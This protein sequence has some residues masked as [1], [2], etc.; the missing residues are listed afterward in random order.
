MSVGEDQLR[1][2]IG[3]HVVISK[4]GMKVEDDDCRADNMRVASK[5]TAS[6]LLQE[7]KVGP[8][9]AHLPARTLVLDAD[10]CGYVFRSG[11]SI[12][13]TQDGAFYRATRVSQ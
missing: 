1:G 12:V 8:K 3:Q 4:S 11:K 2:L 9:D 6:I 7:Y 13:F 5:A 10:P